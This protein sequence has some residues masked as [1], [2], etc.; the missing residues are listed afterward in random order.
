M[1]LKSETQEMQG[2]TVGGEIWGFLYNKFWPRARI[3]E[4]FAVIFR[5]AMVFVY[6]NFTLM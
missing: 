2:K 4:G 6:F 3:F 1:V 5:L